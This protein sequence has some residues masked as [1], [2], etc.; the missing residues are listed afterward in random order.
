MSP[1]QSSPTSD[2]RVQIQPTHDG[3]S[4]SIAHDF[5]QLLAAR[6][7]VRAFLPQ[8]VPRAVVADILQIAARAPSGSNIQPW[9]VYVLVGEALRQVS[10]E[11]IR[12]HDQSLEHPAPSGG[13]S[14]SVSSS[15]SQSTPPP[16]SAPYPYYPSVWVEPYLQRRRDN[17]WGL[18]DKLGILRGEKEKMHR[19]HQANFSFFGAPVG[20]MFTLS[21]ALERGS[22]LDLGM[23]MQ[24]IMLA[25]KARGLDTC[26][27]AAWLPFASVVMPLIGAKE[28]EEMLMCG[29]CL[30]YA[31][32]QASVND[33]LTPREPVE[34][35]TQW[36]SEP[37]EQTHA[38][39]SKI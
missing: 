4:Q 19:Q 23:F 31:D 16:L 35:F 25:A 6:H 29:M 10:L 14:S 9:K 17:G 33:F 21:R 20:L 24:N 22:M 1:S 28:E 2:D 3:A 11:V 7:S 39:Q 36:L 32:R 12:C 8:S 18:Y 30:G 38:N 13:P 37:C 27:Q 5:D 15:T 34:N 26:P